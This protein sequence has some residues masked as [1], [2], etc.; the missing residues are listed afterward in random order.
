MADEQIKVH[1]CLQ[2]PVAVATSSTGCATSILVDGWLC[3]CTAFGVNFILLINYKYAYCLKL[4]PTLF[5]KRGRAES[6]RGVG[7]A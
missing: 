1:S 6:E 2:P 7:R 4:A 5:R 3:M